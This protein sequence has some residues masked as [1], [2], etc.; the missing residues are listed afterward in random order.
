MLIQYLNKFI[1]LVIIV[2]IIS[3][4]TATFH[5]LSNWVIFNYKLNAN[6]YFIRNTGTWTAFI[7]LYLIIY[8]IIGS[9]YYV[10][11]VLLKKRIK[12]VFWK[13]VFIA[14]GLTLFFYV[15]ILTITFGKTGLLSAITNYL[16]LTIMLIPPFILALLIRMFKI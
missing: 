14:E 15:L 8:L 7:K 6:W 9:I 5:Q 1:K 4:L 13:E 11:I 10:V 16:F 3:I 12:L 2:L